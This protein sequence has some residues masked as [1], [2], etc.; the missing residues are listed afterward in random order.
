MRILKLFMSLIFTMK[1]VTEQPKFVTKVH[2]ALK[3]KKRVFIMFFKEKKEF[4]SDLKIVL[5][6]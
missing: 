3:S 5:K 1:I 4:F 2:S 6:K